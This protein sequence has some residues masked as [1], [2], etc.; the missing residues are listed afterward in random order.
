MTQLLKN[1][2]NWLKIDTQ[3][4]LESF[5]NSKH[6]SNAGEIDYWTRQYEYTKQRTE[7]WGQGL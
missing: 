2:T 6:P 1:I 5:I 7:S 3:S 4:E